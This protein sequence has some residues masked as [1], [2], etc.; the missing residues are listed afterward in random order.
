VGPLTARTL[1]DALSSGAA[2]TLTALHLAHTM[3]A[4]TGLEAIA[5]AL[6]ARAAPRLRCGPLTH[7]HTHTPHAPPKPSEQDG[8]KQRLYERP[9]HWRDWAGI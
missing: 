9:T 2:P 4:N 6:A 8:P 3:L 1:A 5:N 7:T